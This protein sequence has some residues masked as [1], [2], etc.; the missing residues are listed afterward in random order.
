MESLKSLKELFL[1][2]LAKGVKR[3]EMFKR[4]GVSGNKIY[5]VM[6]YG[7]SVGEFSPEEYNKIKKY[8]NQD[9]NLLNQTKSEI[10]KNIAID[11]V[12][13]TLREEQRAILPRYFKNRSTDDLINAC[14]VAGL[15]IEINKCIHIEEKGRETTYH[16]KRKEG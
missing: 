5:R 4:I 2:E 6:T 14:R 9:F 7:H 8:F 11:Y 15:E 12:I 13:E 1:K 16:I 3:G 10:Q